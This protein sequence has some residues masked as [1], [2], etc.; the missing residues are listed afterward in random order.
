MYLYRHLVI[1]F[2]I[3][4]VAQAA[5]VVANN[6]QEKDTPLPQGSNESQSSSYDSIDLT[7]EKLEVALGQYHKCNA[8]LKDECSTFETAAANINI[9]FEKYKITT[10]GEMIAIVALMAS[11]SGSFVFNRNH[12]PEPGR[13]GQGTKAMM[14]Y[15]SIYKYANS[16]YPEEVEKLSATESTTDT[17]VMNDVLGLVLNDKDTFGSA[18]WY[19]STEANEY[20]QKNPLD[21]KQSS[22]QKYTTE[23]VGASWDESRGVIWN[24]LNK[25]L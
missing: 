6:T 1:F 11:E 15:P 19:M 22:Y 2:L 10:R 21:G 4:S 7:A 24:E 16:L 20:L 18:A 5:D 17:K 25:A 3:V 23:A 12:Y 13:P 8:E 9:S 14:M